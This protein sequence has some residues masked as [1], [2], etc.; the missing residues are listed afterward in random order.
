MIRNTKKSI[1]L[2]KKTWYPLIVGKIAYI[3]G[4]Y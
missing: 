3:G 4:I 1:D 2:T